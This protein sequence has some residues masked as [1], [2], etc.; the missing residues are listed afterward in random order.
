MSNLLLAVAFAMGLLQTGSV[1][2]I[3]K[4]NM[5]G[6]DEPR[7]VV[8]TTEAEWTTLWKSHA[9]EKPQPKVDFA[10]RRVVAIFLGS[11]PSAGYDIEIVG[12]MTEGKTTVVEWTEVRPKPGMLLAQV[13]T[14]PALI[15]SIPKS[16]GD[17]TFRKVTR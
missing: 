11:R 16:A 5:S 3:A 17:V 6:V 12:T 4:D 7:T 13:L 9:F 8:A 2:T 15:A 1:E 10:T 14:S